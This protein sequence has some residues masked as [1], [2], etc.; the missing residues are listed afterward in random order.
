MVTPRCKQCVIEG[1]GTRRR[2]KARGLCATHLRGNR[3]DRRAVAHGRHVT[4]LYGITAAEYAE[5]LAYQG[6]VC[7][8]CHK[9]PGR[10]RLAVDHDHE[11]ARIHDHPESQGCKLCIRGLLHTKC[12][13]YLGWI[14][15]D[16]KAMIRGA[17]YLTRPPAQRLWRTLLLKSR[18]TV[19]QVK[20]IDDV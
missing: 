13:S 7:F 4:K 9:K 12:N 2:V 8:I 16:P 1:L 10:K 15:D 3:A 11:L 6:G 18:R 19:T 5:L 20:D 17:E 14:R